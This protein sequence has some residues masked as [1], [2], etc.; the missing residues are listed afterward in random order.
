MAIVVRKYF[1]LGNVVVLD[2]YYY[3]SEQKEK[4]RKAES[5][6]NI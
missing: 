1:K 4:K 3:T 2:K 5:M 6:E